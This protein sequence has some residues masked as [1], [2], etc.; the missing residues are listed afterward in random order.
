MVSR[1]DAEWSSWHTA[2]LKMNHIRF[3]KRELVIATL[4]VVVLA[5]ALI[6]AFTV[7]GGF[8]GNG[9]ALFTIATAPIGLLHLIGVGNGTLGAIAAMVVEFGYLL[10]FVLLVRAAWRKFR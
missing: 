1:N 7:L 6:G 4:W 3:W 9:G 8:H 5:V 2:E 10:A